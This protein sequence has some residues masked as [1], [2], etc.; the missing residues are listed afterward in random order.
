MAGEYRKRR[1]C[2]ICGEETRYEDLA[3]YYGSKKRGVCKPCHAIHWELFVRL[4]AK[5][6]CRQCG[7]KYTY[8][9]ARGVMCPPCAREYSRT[10]QQPGEDILALAEETLFPG[11]PYE[12][13]TKDQRDSCIA[14][15]KDYLIRLGKWPTKKERE[16]AA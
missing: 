10:K 2:A 15:A 12:R 5:K 3:T 13:M 1:Y 4:P 11:V 14:W 6:E 16:R 8:R 7:A 9:E